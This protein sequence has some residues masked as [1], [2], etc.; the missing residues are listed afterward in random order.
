MRFRPFVLLAAVSMLCG[1][2]SWPLHAQLPDPY[3]PSVVVPLAEDVTE[4]QAVAEGAL[5]DLGVLAAPTTLTITGDMDSCGW[6][7]AAAWPVWPEHPVDT[8]GDGESDLDQ[9]WYAGWYTGDVDLF[10]IE[11]GSAAWAGVELSW[12]NPPPDGVNAP[13]EP[14]G[15]GPWDS[16]SDLDF[17][18]FDQDGAAPGEVIGENGF[19]RDHPESV[20]SPLVFA[21]G[22]R[23][24]V[25]VGCHHGVPARYTL[26]VTL[27]T[28]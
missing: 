17:V 12:D 1:C 2:D 22:D 14:P 16:E 3:V 5:Q 18:L 28:R 4:D 11:L 9:P 15:P 13:Y 23:V 21:P 8:D 27:G 26:I 10:A 7:D 20:G 24:V 6:D 19:S 25:A